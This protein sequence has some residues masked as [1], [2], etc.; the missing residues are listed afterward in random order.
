VPAGS[1]DRA[2]KVFRTQPQESDT[3]PTALVGESR[4]LE[5]ISTDAPLTEVLNKIWPALDVQA[6]NVACVVMSSEDN[7]HSQ[8]LRDEWPTSGFH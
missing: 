6:G 8:P 2:P 7:E 1:L 5:L 3:I 4:L